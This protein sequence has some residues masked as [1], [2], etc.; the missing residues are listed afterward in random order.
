MTTSRKAISAAIKSILENVS[1]I[2][3]IHEFHRYTRMPEG[4]KEYFTKLV[5]WE[6]RQ[7]NTWLITRD[8]FSQTTVGMPIGQE[9]RSHTFVIRGYMGIKDSTGSE[10]TFQDLVDEIVNALEARVKLGIPDVVEYAYPVSVPTIG[11]SMFG[12]AP[13]HYCEIHLRVD[14][15]RSITYNP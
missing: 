14:E 4:F 1:G 3:T 13:C 8:S 2:G 5:D 7:L 9:M 6:K 15:R 11:H 10:E 12:V